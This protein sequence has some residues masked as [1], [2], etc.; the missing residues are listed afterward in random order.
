MSDTAVKVSHVYKSYRYYRSNLQKMRSLLFGM[1]AGERSEVLHDISFEVF[2]GE[3]VGIIA[4]P[5]SGRSTLMRIMAGVLTPDSGTVEV[6]GK[7]TPVLDHKLGFETTM[8]AKTNYEIRCR[9]MGWTEEEMKE[10]EEK[11]FKRA[12]LGEDIKEPLRK[13]RRGSANR[14]GFAIET[15]M[16]PDIMLF[17]ETFSFGGKK[18]IGKS[19]RR[20]EKITRGENSTLI[21]I[22][23][24]LTKCAEICERGIVLENGR[25]VFDGAYD[26][27]VEYYNENCKPVSKKALTQAVEDAAE[28]A[29]AS[30]FDRESEGPDYDG[31]TESESDAEKEE[32]YDYQS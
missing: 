13:Y 23:N 26:D 20:L 29:A 6:N 4:N 16:K 14:L 8:D 18:Y 10:H 2:R 27:A 31:Y 11:V 25:I 28:A 15:E 5:M 22:V 1:D 24:S 30:E 12:D 32:S 21:M 17:D 7:I 19:F 3:R 9:L